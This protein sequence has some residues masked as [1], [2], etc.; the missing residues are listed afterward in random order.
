M[1]IVDMSGNKQ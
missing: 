1:N